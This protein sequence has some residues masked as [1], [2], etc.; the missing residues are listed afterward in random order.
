MSGFKVFPNEVED[1]AMQHPGVL[2]AAVIGVPDARTGEAV[3]LFVIKRDA[4]LT[5]ADLTSFCRR[6]SST[7]S[8]RTSSNSA[9]ACRRAISARFCARNCIEA[10]RRHYAAF[11]R[12][13]AC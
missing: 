8:G 6:G 5:A 12:D 4:A 1:V 11:L 3:K 7:T 13:G 2:E 10:M 9:T